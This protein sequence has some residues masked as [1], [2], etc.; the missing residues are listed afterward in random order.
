MKPRTA[1]TATI[2]IR[3]SDINIEIRKTAPLL[4]SAHCTTWLDHRCCPLNGLPP[5][6]LQSA[7]AGV[8]IRF[9][10]LLYRFQMS[11]FSCRKH[12]FDDLR[13]LIEANAAFEKSGYSHFIGRIERHSLR[14]S[15][16]RGL[17]GETK[18]REFTHV[19]GAEVEM[20]QVTD[21]KTHIRWDTFGVG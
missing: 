15:C 5:D 1:T 10:H 19:R 3:K 11:R 21:R 17:I 20:T 18:T 4:D 6:P 12:L 13:N 9:K 2:E 7:S 16:L 14:S 8:A